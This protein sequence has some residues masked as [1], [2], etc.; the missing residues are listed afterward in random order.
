MAEC[1]EHERM[2][3]HEAEANVDCI[4]IC[5]PQSRDVG[6]IAVMKGVE[7]LVQGFAGVEEGVHEVEPGIMRHHPNPA[8]RICVVSPDAA[9]I[10]VR[11]MSQ[12]ACDMA[13][14]VLWVS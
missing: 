8:R 10:S 7:V 5:R 1:I 6:A 2:E 13:W 4:P 3:S 12:G 14:Q 9:H 11:C